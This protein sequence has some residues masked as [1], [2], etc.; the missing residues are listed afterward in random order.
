MDALA[1]AVHTLLE[2][3]EAS[4][5]VEVPT[6]DEAAR[7][8]RLF[9]Q[10]LRSGR[11]VHRKMAEG[12]LH[13]AKT[14]S[15]DRLQ[16]LSEFVQ[17]SDDAGAE[18]LRIL[19]RSDYLLVAH[20]G[21]GLHLADVLPLGMPWLSGKTFDA[22]T[23]GR[24]GI[25]LSTLRALTAVWEVH[26]HPFHV[27]FSGTS[28]EPAA[29]PE[30]PTEISGPEWTVFCIPLT[31]GTLTAAQLLAW[32]D[33]WNDASL[34][35]LRHLRSLEVKAGER[36][37][38]LSVTWED[39]TEH[40]LLIEGVEHQVS[41]QHARATDGARWRVYTAQVEPHPNWERSH[42][43]LGP[44]VPVGVALPLEPGAH[45]SV[46][47]GLPVAPLDMAA[48]VHTQFDPVAS[49]EG[50][51]SSL[52]NTQLVPVIADLWAAAVR[53]VLERVDHTAWHLV[54]LALP[55]GSASANLLQDRIRT[56]LLTRARQSLAA[57]LALPVAEDGPNALLAEFAVEEA[58]LSE[59]LDAT[60]I[61]RLSTAPYTLP[62]AVR[63]SAGRWREV[64]S[65]WRAEGAA[66]LRPEVRVTDALSLFSNDEWQDIARLVRL[67][68]VA[69]EAGL[70][71]ALASRTCLATADGRRL[72]PQLAENAFADAS[73]G[74]TGPLDLLGVVL[75]LHPAYAEDNA[76][77]KTV[78][79]WLRQRD[80]LV[81][82]DDTA[83]VLKIVSRLGKAGGRLADGDEAT[84]T[85]RLVALQQALGDMPKKL[86]DPLG[87][88]IG[89]AI[90][91]RGFTYDKDG[92]EQPRRV[93]PDAAYLPQALESAD[94]DRF[95]VAARRTPGLIW[96]RRSYTRSLLSAARAGGLSRTVFLRLLGV[97]DVPRL[98]PVRE[99][100]AD[101]KTYPGDSRIGLARYCRWSITD[102]RHQ[103]MGTGADHTLDDLT[104]S[105]IAAVVK[106]IAAEKNVDERRRRT[107]ALLRTLTTLLTNSDKAVVPMARGHYKWN[108][109][110]ETAAIWVWQLRE[111]A[112][113]E[114]SHGRLKPPAELTLRT[115]DTEALYGPE[116]PGYLHPAI[117]QALATRT[118]V[119]TA[120]G[121][122]GD[123]DVPRLMER[124]R[125]LR[126]R[127][128]EADTD[129]D[130]PDSLR[131]EALL[132]YQSLARR[133]TRR[134][135]DAAQTAVEKQIRNEFRYED[136][137]LTDQG[138]TE[139]GKCFQGPAILRGFRPFA[140]T[141]SDIDPLWQVLGIPE[142]GLDDL[143]DVLKEISGTGAPLDAE[144]E[145]VML[146][147]L[148]R[149][150]DV[151][152]SDEKPMSPGL[153]SRLR[154]LPLWT[155]AGWVKGK[156]QAVFAVADSRVERALTSR[157]PLWQPG[158]NVQQFTALFGPLRITPLDIVGAQVTYESGG[159]DK[160]GDGVL[161]QPADGSLT[162]DFRRGVAALQDLLVRDEPETAEAFTGWAW[163][164]ALEVRLLPGLMIRLDPGDA[165]AP[166]ELPVEAQIDRGRNTL[167]LNS[168]AAL[169]TKAGAGMA[170][171]AHFAE[172]RS[173]LG[174]S[175]RDVW[176][177]H[178]VEAKAGAALTSSG[179]QSREERQRLAEELRRRAQRASVPPMLNAKQPTQRGAS[180]GPAVV[181]PPPRSGSVAAPSPAPPGSGTPSVPHHAPAARPLV[182]ASAFEARPGSIT[183]TGAPY[184]PGN[185]PSRTSGL[186]NPSP[187]RNG[188]PL[189]QP[190]PGGAQPRSQ[191]PPLGY[192]DHDKEELV[193]QALRRILQERGVELDDQRGV[194]GMGADAYDSTGRFYE[195]KAH[196]GTVPSELTLTR[197]EFVRAWSEGENYTLVIASHLEK[198][199]GKPTLRL[200]NDPVHRFEVEPPTDVR[201]KGVRDGAVESTVYEWP[202]SD[203]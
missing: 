78:T 81:R 117:H 45:G 62:A 24:F 135:T 9:D 63:D 70:D 155:T 183:R 198:G 106:N 173:R 69:I 172:E 118:E 49:R 35:F 192:A 67:A 58:A 94:G 141:G 120:L 104:S 180:I 116:D 195:I 28:L 41:V 92:T 187:R 194:S 134:P 100:S 101:T 85:A 57:E 34:L 203:R 200:V 64:L 53:D 149:L 97:A 166:I 15:T 175:W 152:R 110:G 179:Q 86:R 2:D 197:S 169:T 150:R 164:A 59:V 68:A 139:S 107:A 122:S 168:H 189:P 44:L 36:S 51:A 154:S 26:C 188:A 130:V 99:S 178:L 182:D 8:V 112:W 48:R 193:I 14:L 109:K 46:H 80:C 174:H 43:A 128:D 38:V 17:N 55:S 90:L 163:L 89:R 131:A 146:E 136:L 98:T 91:L 96:V 160:A 6:P 147:A 7:A 140:L 137:V 76:W 126:D 47:A 177:E 145:R 31:P 52:L 60:D 22:E 115:A 144:H 124:L 12:A 95:E 156:G 157:L 37:T 32:F 176:E 158:G 165:H 171:A 202:S 127:H 30:L 4:V 148:R 151:I 196:G 73:G 61:A 5:E 10:G 159:V 83:A 29:P 186:A 18:Q 33:D 39:V 13:G 167:F 88:G 20:D 72:R 82:R 93:R 103:M 1:A 114:D 170:I 111:T 113:L 108:L 21:A 199:A 119:L 105:D 190:R 161:N 125:E 77:T 201:L 123:P 27:R 54:P 71:H 3:P 25:G 50:F 65:D 184:T 102:R 87:P 79:T 16:V 23:T 129:A 19:L 11:G 84:E 142:P 132:V 181:V 133:L 185:T 191:A 153:Q 40:R 143:I 121:I 66:D 42:K 162:D 138:W 74:P 75:D 56:T